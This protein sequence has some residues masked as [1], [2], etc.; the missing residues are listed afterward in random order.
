[1]HPS[2]S[3]GPRAPFP[4]LV[5][6]GRSGTT[7]LRAM[8]DAHP[9]LAV[10]PESHFV[11][12]F[13]PASSGAVDAGELAARLAA[14]ERFALWGLDEVTVRDA[15]VEA[16]PRTYADAVRAVFACYADRRG[17]PRYADK[18]PVYVLHIDRLAALFPES[19]FVHLVRDGRDVA[20]SFLELGWADS[21]EEAA[22]HWRRRVTAG[23]RAG[24][25]LPAGRYVEMRYEDLVDSPEQAL[26]RMCD[27]AALPFD[28]AML[29]PSAGA[30][31][32]VRTTAH[33]EYHR[34]LALPPT[35][36]LRDWRRQLDSGQLDRFEL[37]A[38][39]T[40]EAFGYERVAPRPS[41]AAR[42][43][44]AVHWARWQ[45]HRVSKR[46]SRRDERPGRPSS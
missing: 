1:M 33:P 40:L 41:A 43:D 5:G 19:V 8:C 29:D 35:A 13:A 34:H 31:E 15:L 30:A 45:A 36:G 14:S 21:I 28:E 3:D 23:R 26:R 12:A 24:H 22:L 44:A 6:C 18:T 39:T 37:L 32:L 4:F 20:C 10:P 9:S 7:L 16:A 38:G 11:V 42:R 17:K 27:A 2:R 46:V 25:K